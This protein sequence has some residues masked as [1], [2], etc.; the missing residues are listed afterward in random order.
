[1]SLRIFVTHNPEDLDAYYGRALVDLQ[2]LDVEVVLNPTGHD[3][4]TP[5]LIDAASGCHVV[6]AHR[7]TPGEAATFEG[8]GDLV[9]FLRTAVDISTIDVAAATDAG[10]LVGHAD[11]SFVPSTAE[12][13]VGL[14][15][16]AARNIAS[17]TYGGSG[18]TSKKF[19]PT[20]NNMSSSP[21]CAASIIDPA[22]T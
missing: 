21:R 15:L 16:D 2:A 3:L 8:L 12:L 18:N 1:M 7:A 6:V 14:L 22:P 11:K 10:V 20:E 19:P 17:S 9:A 5:E 4:S 13:A